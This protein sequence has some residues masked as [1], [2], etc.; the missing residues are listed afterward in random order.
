M[1]VVKEDQIQA[2]AD[3]VTGLRNGKK[4]KA[5]ERQVMDTYHD[6]QRELANQKTQKTASQRARPTARP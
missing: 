6:Q 2:E 4:D 3:R 1:R 5:C